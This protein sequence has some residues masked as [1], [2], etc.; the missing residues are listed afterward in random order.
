MVKLATFGQVR[1]EVRGSEH[2]LP[3]F[4]VIAA[5]FAAVVAIDNPRMLRGGM[6][7]SLWIKVRPWATANRAALMAAWNTLNP[8]LT[9]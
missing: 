4:H 1:I 5:D 8:T 3:H 2:G 7:A 6:P 9:R